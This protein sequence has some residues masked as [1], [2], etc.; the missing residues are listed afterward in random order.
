MSNIFLCSDHHY[1]H[2]NILN[3]TDET[4][5]RVRDF[6]SVQEMNDTII[7]KHNSVVR[8]SDKVYFLGD[9]TMNTNARGLE[10]LGE[11]NGEKILIKGNHDLCTA[12]QYLKY[13]KD[14]RGSHQLAGFILTHIPIH[15][16]S[17]SRWAANVH[18]HLH[19]HQVRLKDNGI[20]PRY[21]NVSMERIDF[22]P[23]ALDDLV[24]LIKNRLESSIKI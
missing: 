3:F 10:F 14:I 5:A 20:D 22:T 17:L 8:P 11:M 18:G 4:G 21:F 16:D 24:L 9:V 12:Q 2:S 6:D 7:N 19:T 1:N 15:P 13:F 23:V